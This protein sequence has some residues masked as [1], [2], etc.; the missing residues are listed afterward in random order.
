[1]AQIQ[2]IFDQSHY[3]RLIEGR[4]DL[5]RRLVTEFKASL[6]LKTALDAGCGVGFFAWIL[7][8]CGLAVRAF[9]GRNENVEEARKRYQKISFEQG[10]I[11]DPDILRLGSFDL[12]LCFG[13]LYHL[14]NPLLAI[15]HLRALTGK[16]LLLERMCLP[17][18]KP[19]MLLRDE[20]ALEDHSLSDVAFYPTE[21]CI[22]KMLYHAGFSTVYGTAQ[23][24]HPSDLRHTAT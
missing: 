9:D 10:D 2:L 13:L 6:S 19:S 23:L 24:P 11:Q 18:E 14:E 8:E 4:G 3:Q 5:I 20:P 15:R 1:M 22:V 7:E 21:G 12:V 16:A 17:D